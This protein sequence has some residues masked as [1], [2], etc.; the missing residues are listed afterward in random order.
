MSS[1]HAPSLALSTVQAVGGVLERSAQ[2]SALSNEQL[3]KRIA[4]HQEELKQLEH[5]LNTRN[6]T[7]K[8]KRMRTN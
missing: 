4:E 8:R 5:E 6:H 3:N 2:P 1:G 7:K